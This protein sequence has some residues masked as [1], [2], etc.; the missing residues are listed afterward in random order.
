MLLIN[1]LLAAYLITVTFSDSVTL[2]KVVC[3]ER[4]DCFP[5]PGVTQ[6]AC[7]TRGCIWDTDPCPVWERCKSKKHNLKPLFFTT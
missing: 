2:P 6:Q 4:L 5:E 7:E 1:I 3:G